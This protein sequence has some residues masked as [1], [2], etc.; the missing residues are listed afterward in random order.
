MALKQFKTESKRILDLMINSIY[1]HKEIFLRELIS[2]ASDALDKL[3]YEALSEGLTG[4]D[5]ADFTIQLAVDSDAR[6]LTITDNGIGMAKDDLENNLGIIAKSGSLQFKKENEEAEDI[7]IIGQFGVGFY[8]SFMVSDEVSVRSKAYG[9]DEAFLW[10]SKGV[11]GYRITPCEMAEHG[12]VITLHMKENTEDENYDEFLQQYKLSSLVKKYSDY[13]RYPIQM[14]MQKTKRKEGTGEDGKEIEYESYTEVETLNSMVPIWKKGKQEVT[15]EEYTAFYKEKFADW[16]DPLCSVKFSAEGTATF[17]AL[18]FIPK[19]APMDYYSKDYEKGLQL[20]ASG[21]MIT[22]KCADLLPDHFSFVKGLVD[23]QDLSLNISR[24][25]LQHDRQLKIIAGRIEKK[26]GSELKSMLQNDR[27]KYEEFF[28]SF[29]LQLKFGM[30]DGYGA[31]KDELKDLI[32]FYSSTEKK[33]VTLSE[34]V[35]RMK[36]DQQYIYYACGETYER[37][38]QLPQ[39][40]AVSE[41]GY[42]LLCLTDNIDEFAI[43]MLIQYE[44]KEFRNI[45]ADEIDLQSEDEKEETKKLKESHQNMLDFMKDALDGKVKEVRISTRL[46]RHPVCISTDGAISTE[47]EKVLNAMP[48]QDKVKAERVLELNSGHPVFESLS[49]LYGKDDDKLKLYTEILYDE[50][51]LI[52]GLAIENPTEFAAKVSQLMAQ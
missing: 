24:E 38:M 18:L 50:A 22:E 5:R 44:E 49:A 19:R 17:D 20:Y 30:Y 16:Q 3:Y 4:L 40:D 28:K 26:I 10:E 52:E 48:N 46:K 31:H 9:S 1:T 33:M 12:T 14:E 42:E 2:N 34:Y 21:V 7:D 41:K 51:L 23:S 6:T 25:M 32:L 45:S 27:E 35:S 13:I 39:A 43:K 36:T 29:G 15:T 8:S 47:M 37:A 11:E